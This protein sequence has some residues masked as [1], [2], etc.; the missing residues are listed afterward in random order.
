MISQRMCLLLCSST[1][2]ELAVIAALQRC[3]P[4]ATGREELSAERRRPQK[5]E[6][7]C[8]PVS[9]VSWNFWQL[10]HQVRTIPPSPVCCQSKELGGCVALERC[11]KLRFMQRQLFGMPHCEVLPSELQLTLA[12]SRRVCSW[13]LK[14]S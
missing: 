8:L 6:E 1:G 10:L 4:T 13:H 14:I 3:C 5:G 9:G 2:S 11:F 12:Q 7:L